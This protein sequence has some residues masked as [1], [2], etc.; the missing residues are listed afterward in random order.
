MVLRVLAVILIFAVSQAWAVDPQA[1][2]KASALAQKN[3]KESALRLLEMNYNLRS[4]DLPLKVATLAASLSIAVKQWHK[5]EQVADMAIHANW[6]DWPATKK[7]KNQADLFALVR[8]SA[9]A[10]TE[11]FTSSDEDHARLK[12]E[13][14][15]YTDYLDESHASTDD[16]KGLMARIE[17]KSQVKTNEYHYG[18]AVTASYMTWEDRP[19]FDYHLSAK[20]KIFTPCYGLDLN[21]A[22]DQ[23]EWAIGACGGGGAASMQFNDGHYDN[24]SSVTLIAG[25]G[26]GLIQLNNVGA[27]FG[28]ETSV[29]NVMTSGKLAD[30]TRKSVSNEEFAVTAVGRYRLGKIDMKFKGGPVISNPS[31]LWGFEL[32]YIF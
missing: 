15:K 2:D 1:Y 22:N 16:S 4:H 24:R 29:M 21:Y 18:F 10:K 14:K 9:Q 25:Y 31:A 12:A 8:M 3:R 11:I 6:P 19:S 13:I 7:P 30:G 5:A 17:T 23:F 20:E 26:S 27:A 28:V 32:S